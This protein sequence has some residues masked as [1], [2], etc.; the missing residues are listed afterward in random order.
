M[1]VYIIW[2]K[3]M[4]F[5]GI[6]ADTKYE[7]GLKRILENKLNTPNKEHTIIA[8]NAKSID[9]IKNIRFE[10]ILIMNLNKVEEKKEVLNE[11]FKNSKYLV[12]NADMESKL[13]LTEDMK[14]NVITFGFNSKSTI[15]ASSVEESFIICLQRNLVDINCNTLEP[16]E[17]QVKIMEK[18]LL[19]N[20]HNIM[21]IASILLIYGRE[22]NFF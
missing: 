7:S 21:G 14:V 10:T 17:I 13:I 12:I 2:R 1:N 15:T 16:Q 11:L 18:K 19:N 20:S 3:Q 8:I 6:I 9:N 4:A 22:E 5:I